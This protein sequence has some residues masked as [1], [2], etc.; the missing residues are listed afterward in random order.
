MIFAGFA[1]NGLFLPEPDRPPLELH[2]HQVE[3][4]ARS[5]AE[6]RDAVILTGTGSGKTEAIYLPIL[7][8]LARESVQW[9]SL[10]RASRSDWWA[11]DPPSGSGRRTHHPRIS[12]R[13]HEAGGRMPAVRALVLYPLNALAEDQMAR[14]RKALDGDE[15]RAWLEVQRPGNRF[16]SAG[17]RAGRQSP[18]VRTGPAQ[19]QIFG[20]SLGACPNLQPP[21]A[22]PPPSASFPASMVGRCG[23]GGTCKMRT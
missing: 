4:L 6:R 20:A 14:L 13:A 19:K 21:S 5:V 11:M 3:M 10:P 2:A 17:T 8:A 7:A 23:A 9:P 22:A 1:A 15:A 16:G 18:D 12:Q